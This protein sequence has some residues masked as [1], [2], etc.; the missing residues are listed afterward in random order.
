[1]AEL[2][3]FGAAVWIGLGIAAPVGPIGLLVIQRT[4]AHGVPLGLA[5]GLGAAVADAMYGALGA[6]GVSTVIGAL[7]GLRVPLV[8]AG[9]G[10]LLVLAWRTWHGADAAAPGLEPAPEPGSERASEG[11]SAVARA[12]TPAP[13]LAGA[14]GGTVLLTLS[15]PATI[16]SFVAIFGAL[17]AQQ[18]AVRSPLLMVAGV[19]VGS[20]L[21]WLLLCAAV[22]ALRERVDAHWRRRIARGSA[23]MLAGFAVLQLAMLWGASGGAG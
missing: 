11:A 4:L 21:W 18:Q 23:L 15:N 1:M 16:L 20:A 13:G 7:Q 2:A 10:F 14:F 6:Y 17:A 12:A 3:L 5:T 8:L 22:G 19:L 9:A